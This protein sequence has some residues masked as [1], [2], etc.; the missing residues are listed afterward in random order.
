MNSKEDDGLVKLLSNMGLQTLSQYVK[1]LENSNN[2]EDEEVC[3]PHVLYCMTTITMAAQILLGAMDKTIVK[4]I[5]DLMANN[6]TAS[7]NKN[8]NSD[9]QLVELAVTSVRE[10]FT[11][12]NNSIYKIIGP[13]GSSSGIFN[14]ENLA[15]SYG[16]ILLKS[17]DIKPSDADAMLDIESELH[18]KTVKLISEIMVELDPM[19]PSHIKRTAYTFHARNGLIRAVKQYKEMQ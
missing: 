2:E 1:K 5:S 13:Q 7:I 6:I 9:K 11:H 4:S 15:F 17:K 14:A 8:N 18:K 19:F 3:I 12:A 10:S 16:M